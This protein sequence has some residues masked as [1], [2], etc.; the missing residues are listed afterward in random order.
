[1]FQ[2][3]MTCGLSQEV[4]MK[5]WELSDVDGDGSLSV[6]EFYVN[7]FLVNLAQT[8]QSLPDVLPQTLINFGMFY[9]DSYLLV[10]TWNRYA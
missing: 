8:G 9:S 3:L 4:L 6:K 5:I 7:S 10:P 2:K 1:M